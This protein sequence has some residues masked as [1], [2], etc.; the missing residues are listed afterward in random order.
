MKTLFLSLFLLAGSL[1]GQTDGPT[2]LPQVVPTIPAL[3]VK[4]TR[5]TPATAAGL[6]QAIHSAKCGDNLL[7]PVGIY[8]FTSNLV[9][10]CNITIQGAAMTS[11][12]PPVGTRITP[13][14]ANVASLP[15]RPSFAGV[16]KR[17]IPQFI[18]GPSA[19]IVAP[20]GVHFANVEI[21][22]IQ[23]STAFTSGLISSGMNT[24]L[25]RVYCHGAP[26]AEVQRCVNFSSGSGA[27][28][29]SYFSGF[30]C[31]ANGSCSDAQAIL[32]GLGNGGGPVLV[33]NNFLEASGENI[34]SG[35]GGATGTQSDITISH[36]HFFKPL[37]WMQ[38]DPSFAGTRMIVK[39]LLELKNANRVLIEYNIFENSWGGFSQNGYAILLTPKNQGGAAPGATVSNVTIRF[40]DVVSGSGMQIAVAAGDP[41]LKPS[42]KGMFNISI[43]DDFFK[44]D[45]KFFASAGVGIQLTFQDPA[46][47]FGA[48]NIDHLTVVGST[49]SAF[50]FGSNKAAG[51][52]VISN[53]LFEPGRYDSTTTGSGPNDCSYQLNVKPAQA[54]TQCWTSFFFINNSVPGGRPNVWPSGTVLT[55]GVGLGVDQAGLVGSLKGVQ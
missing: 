16:V 29:D 21:T 7:V 10:P 3:S 40:N 46:S 8:T 19:K 26:N 37:I 22:V 20:N 11:V 36:N 13:A 23:S 27:V 4:G 38:S 28:V 45:T 54:L 55:P 43:H 53:S 14:Y 44:L 9:I 6:I 31:K 49:N 12:L 41:P 2:I 39:N 5:V 1:F 15:G 30:Q 52:L 50:M 48:I 47:S 33:R 42:S 17:V 32:M 24:I 34:L 35:G 18:L 51:P 25:E